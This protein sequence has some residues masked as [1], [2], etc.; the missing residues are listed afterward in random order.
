MKKLKYSIIFSVIIV[1][2]HFFQN[3]INIFV[4]TPLGTN[5]ITYLIYGVLIPFFILVLIKVLLKRN[6]VNT[7]TILLIIGIVLYF[8][9]I[10]SQT[11]LISK[12]SLFEFISIGIVYS[13]EN[14]NRRSLI[15]IILI[16]FTAVLT[17]F[18]V[19]R[20]L[21]ISFYHYD[22]F[23]KILLSFA[24]YTAAAISFRK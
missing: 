2:I 4:K 23:L 17:E 14:K 11:L 8:F 7:T 18:A 16:L 1:F 10:R 19:H 15:P 5:I 22:V 12:L 24:G 20:S 3:E 9:M 6:D 13:F 21:S